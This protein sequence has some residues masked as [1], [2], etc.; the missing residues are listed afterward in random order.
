MGV[1]FSRETLLEKPIVKMYSDDEYY[2]DEYSGYGGGHGGQEPVHQDHFAVPY[3]VKKFLQYF[4][5][6]TK[7]IE[8]SKY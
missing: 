1:I 3:Q 5:V 8:N 2:E 7:E 6:R 4:Q